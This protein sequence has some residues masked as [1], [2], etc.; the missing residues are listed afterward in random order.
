MITVGKSAHTKLS[1]LHYLTLILFLL[2]LAGKSGLS[3]GQVVL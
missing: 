2:T 1:S 3:A